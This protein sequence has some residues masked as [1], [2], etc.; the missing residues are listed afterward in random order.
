MQYTTYLVGTNHVDV[1][2]RREVPGPVGN[3]P[4]AT[5]PVPEIEEEP[6]K[7]F[8]K[9]QRTSR[10]QGAC[11]RLSAW[12]HARSAPCNCHV[13]RRYRQRLEWVLRVAVTDAAEAT[14]KLLELLLNFTPTNNSYLTHM[15]TGVSI[16][17]M[18]TCNTTVPVCRQLQQLCGHHTSRSSVKMTITESSQA[19]YTP[20]Y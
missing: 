13:D 3:F 11:A 1:Q 6:Q 5:R 12:S 4:T 18:H 10:F 9:D 20:Q 2:R 14:V 19:S 7:I 15:C 8:I 17:L 16:G